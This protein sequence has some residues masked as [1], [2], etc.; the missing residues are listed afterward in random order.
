[1]IADWFAGG[2]SEAYVFAGAA[3]GG[4]L[5]TFA[6]TYASLVPLVVIALVGAIPWSSPGTVDATSPG[7]ATGTPYV[8]A[9]HRQPHRAEHRA[10]SGDRRRPQGISRSPR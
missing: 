1:V 9:M 7:M 4:L 3:A 10:T 2:S 8:S 5:L 6:R